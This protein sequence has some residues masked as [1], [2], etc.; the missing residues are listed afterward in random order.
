[1][2]E[3]SQ[4]WRYSLERPKALDPATACKSSRIAQLHTAGV[5][6]YLTPAGGPRTLSPVTDV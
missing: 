5:L 3:S 6:V 1:M 4:I 2:L